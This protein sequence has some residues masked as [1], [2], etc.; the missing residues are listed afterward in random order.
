M[1]SEEY[2][3]QY[4]E[5]RRQHAKASPRRRRY[6]IRQALNRTNLSGE[7][8]RLERLGVNKRITARL[9]NRP[10]YLLQDILEISNSLK[11]VDDEA[12]S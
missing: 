5:G 4:E 11:S 7:L 2:E 6:D 10:A 8:E 1:T 3:K 12:V 9:K